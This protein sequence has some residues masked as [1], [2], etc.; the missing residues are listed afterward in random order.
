MTGTGVILL[1]HGSRGEQEPCERLK[2]VARRLQVQLGSKTD[3]SWASLQFNRPSLVEAVEEAIARGVDH[4]T[5]LPYFLFDGT[6]VNKDIPLALD[7]LR[8]RHPQVQIWLAKTLGADDRIVD[9]LVDRLS[10]A[11]ELQ[12]E[13]IGGVRK[14]HNSPP[15]IERESM[16]IIESLLSGRPPFG[17]EREIVKRIVHAA[18]DVGIADH[19]QIHPEAVSAGV[20]AIRMGRPVLTDVRMLAVGIARR[21]KAL[22]V[23]VQCMVDDPAIEEQAKQ[24]GVTRSEM[25]M[26]SF[27]RRLDGA[28]VAIGNAPTALL[29]TLDIVA[30]GLATPA[31]IVG[32]PVGF[33]GAVESKSELVKRDVPYITVCGTRGG[34]ALAAAAVNALF[35][36]AEGRSATRPGERA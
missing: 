9:V 29:A 4:L 19:V 3:V 25:A 6:H 12:R 28:I 33:V 36:M 24:K 18:G 35:L 20:N 11:T 30:E 23:G 1:G 5:V 14:V 26:R 10:E 31:L 7:D 22:G 17:M 32:M 27:G 16:A 15:E 13:D 21:A 34:S 8:S 2:E